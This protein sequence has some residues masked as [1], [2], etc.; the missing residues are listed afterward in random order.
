MN[1]NNFTRAKRKAIYKEAYETIDLCAPDRR[2]I[3]FLLREFWVG[4]PRCGWG[5]HVVKHFPEI[6]L[7]AYDEN[8]W[9]TD[10]WQSF[11]MNDEIRKNILLLAYH[12][13]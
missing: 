3:C 4:C 6:A 11:S 13:L 2:G 7:F 5:H 12:M 8:G 1:T 9:N 10:Y